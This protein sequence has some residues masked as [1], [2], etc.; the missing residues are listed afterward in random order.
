MSFPG[1]SARSELQVTSWVLHVPCHGW[2]IVVA[3]YAGLGT[4]YTCVV[5]DPAGVEQMRYVGA[6]TV[7][8][9][10]EHGIANVRA[11]GVP[12]DDVYALTEVARG[13]DGAK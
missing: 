2:T 10:L 6:D 12:I 4:P 5:V 7:E 1:V 3:P 13:M 8:A 11:W 9:A